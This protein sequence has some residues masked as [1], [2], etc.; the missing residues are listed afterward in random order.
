MSRQ[1]YTN[2]T[3]FEQFA[4]TGCPKFCLTKLHFICMGFLITLWPKFE[5]KAQNGTHLNAVNLSKLDT[6]YIQSYK[7]R[8]IPS[9]GLLSRNQLIAVKNQKLGT[10]NF[11]ANVQN[12]IRFGATYKGI[13]LHVAFAPAFLNSR[14][15][16]RS[17]F[18]NLRIN[19]Y[20][21]KF[22]FLFNTL[23]TRGF[24]LSNPQR[25]FPAW[26]EGF[27]EFPDMR[28]EEYRLTAFYSFNH[29]RYSFR[30]QN[31]FN[32]LQIKSA[33]SFVVG[34]AS[35]YFSAAIGET[36]LLDSLE[37]D[38]NFKGLQSWDFGPSAGYAHT[39]VVFKKVYASVF[40][41]TGPL[42]YSART[43]QINR[44]TPLSQ[45]GW[46]NYFNL[47]LGRN[48]DRLFYGISILAERKILRL[49]QSD[50]ETGLGTLWLF[51]GYRFGD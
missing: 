10:L 11:R 4:K 18:F 41:F 45:M 49:S 9:L 17:S 7:H 8:F 28:A 51:L 14:N 34:F 21:R 50:A 43:F 15:I 19:S 42:V 40:L 3:L 44:V 27:P 5:A 46:N 47:N 1:F 12:S 26:K 29:R 2:K 35:R 33:G 24:Y 32:E 16:T 39:F 36:D 6:N 20:G 38:F 25:L 22:S 13:G 30:H 48:T 31:T 23:D 37:G